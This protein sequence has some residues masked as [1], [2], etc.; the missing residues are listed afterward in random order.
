MTN[1]YDT[2]DVDPE[3]RKREVEARRRAAEARR[4][5]RHAY[6]RREVGMD[7][8]PDAVCEI[9]GFRIPASCIDNAIRAGATVQT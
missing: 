7:E 2:E 5:H 9:C 8:K 4:P 3:G 6:V 1:H